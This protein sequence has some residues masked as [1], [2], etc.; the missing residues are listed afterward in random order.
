MFDQKNDNQPPVNRYETFT[1]SLPKDLLTLKQLFTWYEVHCKRVIQLLNSNA[2]IDCIKY[3]LEPQEGF[4]IKML[5]SLTL[6]SGFPVALIKDFLADYSSRVC[7]EKMMLET[8]I[9]EVE[10]LQKQIR[11]N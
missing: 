5:Q 11:F 8:Y 10:L 9:G 3:D 6:Q 7:S 2:V 4:P 1:A